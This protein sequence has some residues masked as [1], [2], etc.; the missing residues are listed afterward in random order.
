MSFHSTW[1]H[2]RYFN[3][4][5]SLLGTVLC[6]SVMLLMDYRTSLATLIFAIL[7]YVFVRTR[8]PDVN[9]GSSPQSQCFVSALKAV[10]ALS[11]VEDHVKNYRPKLLVLSGDPRDR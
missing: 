4:W 10:Q 5:V 6:I 11:R 8:R 7:L 1:N 2:H 9:W 3:K